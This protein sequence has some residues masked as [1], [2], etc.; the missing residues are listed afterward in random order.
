MRNILVVSL[1][2]TVLLGVVAIQAQAPAA[3][4]RTVLI[5]DNLAPMPGPLT[6]YVIEGE[7]A[8]GAET[9]WH[10]HPGN[11]F[12]CIR[13]GELTLEVEGKATRT[14]KGGTAFHNEPGVKHNGRNLSK[15][16]PVKYFAVWVLEQG[17]PATSPAPAPAKQ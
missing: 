14:Y 10:T 12:T 3:A 9:G 16:E 4:K 5:Q 6:G 11:D 7:L 8:P 13:S 1:V 15:T 2:L 17:K